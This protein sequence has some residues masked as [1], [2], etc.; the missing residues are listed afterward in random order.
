MKMKTKLNKSLIIDAL[1]AAVITDLAPGLINKYLFASKPLTGTA[2]N[3]ASA[4]A[5]YVAGG[6]MKKPNVA[7]IGIALAGSN[8]VSST[9]QGF[10]GG[11][12]NA[13]VT[14]SEQ[15]RQDA[16]AEYVRLNDYVDYPVPASDYEKFYS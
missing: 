3:I 2:L 14:K 8:L 9:I 6:L 15:V 11:S 4:G 16:L 1:I 10:V 13:L 5:A 7:N 12:N